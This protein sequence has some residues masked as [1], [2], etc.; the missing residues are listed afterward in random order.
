MNMPFVNDG[1]FVAGKS[2]VHFAGNGP[3][4]PGIY[5]SSIAVFHNLVIN[6]PAAQ[7]GVY[8]NFVITDTITMVDG[9]LRLNGDTCTLSDT[10]IILGES[11]K[12]YITGGSIITHRDLYAPNGVNPGN[13]G[14]GFTTPDNI[15]NISII[16]TNILYTSDDNRISIGRS[17]LVTPAFK[18]SAPSIT[19]QFHYLDVELFLNYEDKLALWS[20]ALPHLVTGTNDLLD[21]VNNVITETGISYLNYFTAGSA[22]AVFARK[23]FAVVPNIKPVDA[24]PDVNTL[25]VSPNPVRNRFVLRLSAGT[26]GEEV[27]SLYS[28]AGNLLQRKVITYKAGITSIEWDISKETAGIYYL[29]FEKKAFKGTTIVKQ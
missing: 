14:L 11:E 4:A 17:Y 29:R 15:T 1:N 18:L 25:V 6:K 12:S 21:G 24:I 20:G 13:I 28:F 10:A 7:V 23:A 9:M 8:Q 22:E 27:A 3:V 19:V 16:R 5:G 26:A 2:T